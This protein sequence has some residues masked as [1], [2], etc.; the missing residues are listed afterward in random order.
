MVSFLGLAVEPETA[1]SPQR[2]I[3]A[4]KGR[5]GNRGA[6]RRSTAPARMLGTQNRRDQPTGHPILRA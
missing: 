3:G 5:E 1:P 6:D 4:K 2:H